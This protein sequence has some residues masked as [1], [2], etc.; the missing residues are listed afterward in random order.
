MRPTGEV[1][2]IVRT[3]GGGVDDDG[4]PLPSKTERTPI[5]GAVV[6]DGG[7]ELVVRND[8][9]IT[10]T[11]MRVLF[12]RHVDVK[13]GDTLEVRALKYRIDEDP[14]DHSSQWGRAGTGGTVAKI[15]RATA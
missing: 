8:G 5:P 7:G 12:P 2:T 6:E 14:F 13:R 9:T 4:Y 11:K 15:V 10:T 1:V 3:T